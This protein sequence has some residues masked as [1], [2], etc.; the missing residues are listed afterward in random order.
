MSRSPLCEPSS[1]SRV[2]LWLACLSLCA[3]FATTN[4]RA[5]TPLFEAH[6]VLE[7]SLPIDFRTLCRP[8]EMPDCD[9]TPTVLEYVDEHGE[10]ITEPISKEFYEMLRTI[11]ESSYYTS[12]PEKACLFVPAIDLLDQSRIGVERT[13][14]V[15]AQLPK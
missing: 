8:R 1:G 7:L 3:V 6:S 5:D 10:P 11:A 15:L 14:Q 12:D 2:P 4:I 13:G 9:Y